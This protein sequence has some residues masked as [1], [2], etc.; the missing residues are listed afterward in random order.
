MKKLKTEKK[1]KK[2]TTINDRNTIKNKKPLSL[3]NNSFISTN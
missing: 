1:R 3:D 2:E